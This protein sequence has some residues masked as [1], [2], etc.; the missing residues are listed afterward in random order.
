MAFAFPRRNF[1]ASS[2]S[3]LQEFSKALAHPVA[4]QLMQ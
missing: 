2:L 3:G 1:F 4:P